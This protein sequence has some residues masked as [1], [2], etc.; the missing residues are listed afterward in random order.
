MPAKSKLEQFGLLEE[1]RQLRKMEYSYE[2]IAEK[3]KE[4]HPGIAELKNLSAMSV[5][6]ALNK[7][8]EREYEAELDQGKDP[9]QKF[10]NEYKAFMKDIQRKSR[11]G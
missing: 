3:L 7:S 5:M 9:L 11:K 6:R 8:V 1:A 2:R 4:N 10:E